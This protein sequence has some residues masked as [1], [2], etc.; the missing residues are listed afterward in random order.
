MKGF[1]EE[2]KERRTHAGKPFEVYKIGSTVLYQWD[3]NYFGRVKEGD[4]LEY[5]TKEYNDFKNIIVKKIYKVVEEDEYAKMQEL[6]SE[7]ES[8]IRMSALKSSLNLIS[9]L[10][11]NPYEKGKLALD[12]SGQFEK[13]IRGE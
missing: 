12:I 6:V 3:R 13:Y 11:V 9:P 5:E 2:I 1:V 10:K 8:H 4:L 7:K